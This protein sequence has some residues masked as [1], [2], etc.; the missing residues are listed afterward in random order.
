MDMNE[1]YNFIP[2]E[3]ITESSW[4]LG[5][6]PHDQ[7]SSA[8]TLRIVLN[9]GDYQLSGRSILESGRLVDVMNRGSTYLSLTNAWIQ[10]HFPMELLDRTLEQL[11]INVGEVLFAS[12]SERPD[13]PAPAPAIRPATTTGNQRERRRLELQ[14]GPML[15]QGYLHVIPG[16]DPV[17]FYFNQRAFVPL[18]DALAVYLPDPERQWR[19][20]VLCVNTHRT[21]FVFAAENAE[22][23]SPLAILRNRELG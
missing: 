1:S 2:I 20:Q 9:L 23:P 16:A 18:T 11:T 5:R 12:P 19:R 14:I 6:L 15:V 21:Q 7:T 4:I 13:T 22:H 10:P 3:L 17:A 8:E